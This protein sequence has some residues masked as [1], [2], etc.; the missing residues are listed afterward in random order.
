MS[1]LRASA[2]SIYLVFISFRASREL[3]SI[4]PSTRVEAPIGL[5]MTAMAVWFFKLVLVCRLPQLHHS[6]TVV[7]PLAEAVHIVLSDCE[8]ILERRAAVLLVERKDI[9]PVVDL[10][11]KLLHLGEAE[12]GLCTNSFGVGG[13]RWHWFFS[14][15]PVCFLP[16]GPPVKHFM[17]RHL[18]G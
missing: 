9:I 14:P 4:V 1:L 11:V 13:H 18:L 8:Y 16:T 17:R 3:R 15:V 10:V 12:A 5:K 7:A 6:L 2:A